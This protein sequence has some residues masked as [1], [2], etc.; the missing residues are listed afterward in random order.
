MADWLDFLAWFMWA[1]VGVVAGWPAEES[2]PKWQWF[3]YSILV[4]VALRCVLLACK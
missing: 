1:L 3:G 2:D 4:V